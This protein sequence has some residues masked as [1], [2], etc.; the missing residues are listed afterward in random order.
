MRTL[1]TAFALFASFSLLVACGDDGGDGGGSACDTNMDA[2]MR[3]S[4]VVMANC[5]GCHSVSAADRAGAP[6]G[7]DFDSSDD[8]IANEARIRARAIDLMTMPP[9][10]PLSDA[11]VADL[12]ALLDCN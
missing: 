10:G 2:Q 6:V 3:G 9:A 4:T 8:I 5:L 7:V 1:L 12:Q 11:N